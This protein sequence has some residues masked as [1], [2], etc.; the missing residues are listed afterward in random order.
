RA[1]RVRVG[2][3]PLRRSTSRTARG[4]HHIRAAARPHVSVRA[5][6]ADTGPI[7]PPES[8]DPAPRRAASHPPSMRRTRLNV[9]SRVRRVA[10]EPASP[11]PRRGRP[12]S[13]T[14]ERI[15][16]ALLK[17]AGDS[18]L[19][20]VSMRALA[21]ELRAPVMTVYNYIPSKG[22]LHELVVNH[23]LRPT[24]FPPLEVGSWEERMRQLQRQVRH[25]I[26]RHPALSLSRYGGGGTEA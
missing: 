21:K 14:E 16:E 7:A 11:G 20:D 24:R 23:V 6:P 17:L 10:T 15:V 22:A 25:A 1:R 19:E 9:R 3:S 4:T 8:H 5:G 2:H 13:L 18:R 26:G 12:R